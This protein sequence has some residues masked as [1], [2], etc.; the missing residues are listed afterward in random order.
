MGETVKGM[1]SAM[2]AM[3]PV[4]ISAT[5]E[6]FEKSFEDMDVYSRTIETAMESTT[7]SMTPQEEVDNLIQ[8][9]ADQAGLTL[10]GQMDG[11]GPVGTHGVPSK[12]PGICNSPIFFQSSI[13]FSLVLSLTNFF[14]L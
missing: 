7:G 5:M 13:A 6:K 12:E 14:M 9:V 2:Q 3:D 4:K 10:S 11:A 1:S 8:M